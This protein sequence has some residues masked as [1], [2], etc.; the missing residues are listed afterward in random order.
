MDLR[1]NQITVGELLGN[2]A[3]RK[4]FQQRFPGVLRHPLLGAAQT[5]TL[6]QLA[7][8][9]GAYLPKRV[10]EETLQELKNL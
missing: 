5:V 1:N 8:F 7:S 9:A 10:I 6:E 3:A 4:V 2:P